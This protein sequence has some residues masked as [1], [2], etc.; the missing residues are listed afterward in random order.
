MAGIALVTSKWFNQAL[1]LKLSLSLSSGQMG[2]FA[3]FNYGPKLSAKLRQQ[4]IQLKLEKMQLLLSRDGPK[5]ARQARMPPPRPPPRTGKI[6]FDS[7]C[8]HRK[9]VM[10]ALRVLA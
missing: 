2:G 1:F 3:I 4:L 6:L 10:Q 5:C 7:S 8:S 9:Q